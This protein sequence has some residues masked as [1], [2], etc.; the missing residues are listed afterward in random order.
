M[1]DHPLDVGLA[2]GEQAECIGGLKDRHPAARHGSATE[3]AC[4][5]QKFGLQR[6][7][8]DVG[9]PYVRPQKL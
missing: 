1:P 3:R 8:D 7:I 9:H 4:D 5:S 6:K 2:T